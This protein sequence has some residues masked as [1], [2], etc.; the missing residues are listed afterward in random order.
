ML[1][2]PEFAAILGSL[3]NFKDQLLHSVEGQTS[4]TFEW[5]D[6]ML[7]QSLRTGDWLLMDNVNF[8]RYVF[9]Y[10]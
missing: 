9:K 4:G 3:R 1:V 7:V 5:V 6:G 8:C 2:L 10:T